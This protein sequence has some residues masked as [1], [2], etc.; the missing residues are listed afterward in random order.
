MNPIRSTSPTRTNLT[1]QSP[2]R[3]LGNQRN[4]YHHW[5][6]MLRGSNGS[7]KLGKRWIV[8]DAII[9]TQNDSQR[10]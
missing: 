5:G 9:F 8:D 4:N 1:S 2:G 3:S 10:V 7:T 6:A